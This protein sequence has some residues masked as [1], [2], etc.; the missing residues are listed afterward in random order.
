MNETESAQA[1]ND[2]NR[3]F[4]KLEEG[5]H[6]EHP[7]LGGFHMTLTFHRGPIW[8]RLARWGWLPKVAHMQSNAQVAKREM[9]GVRRIA[10][11]WHLRKADLSL[12]SE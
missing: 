6:A 5:N 2:E 10:G 8:R 12:R 9:T 3:G 11:R 4:E 7:R 1:D